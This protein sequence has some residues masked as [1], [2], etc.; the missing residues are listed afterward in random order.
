MHGAPEAE[1]AA[2]PGIAEQKGLQW[3]ACECRQRA[4][5]AVEGKGT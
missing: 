1:L 4:K 5:I 3:V 2:N